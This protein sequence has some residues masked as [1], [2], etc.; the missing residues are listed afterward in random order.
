MFLS[1]LLSLLSVNGIYGFAPFNMENAQDTADTDEFLKITEYAKQI[2]NKDVFFLLDVAISRDAKFNELMRTVDNILKCHGMV[3]TGFDL[4]HSVE[5]NVTF[6]TFD[7][8]IRQEV[9]LSSCKSM[10]CLRNIADEMKQ[11]SST[12]ATGDALKRVRTLIKSSHSKNREKT[13]ILVTFGPP[14]SSGR[15]FHQQAKKLVKKG[16][17]VIIIGLG[18]EAAKSKSEF[19]KVKDI[20]GL[21][22]KFAYTNENASAVYQ[23]IDL[24]VMFSCG[25]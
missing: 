15:S 8:E 10:N 21:G 12:R 24:Y 7:K 3:G 19:Q 22:E 11:T 23:L 9:V 20:E 4:M 18:K 6:L 5:N 25:L 13:V 17:D 16:H 1:I 14:S 2:S